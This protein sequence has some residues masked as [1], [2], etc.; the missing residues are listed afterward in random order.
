MIMPQPRVEQTF[1]QSS[2]RALVA[3]HSGAPPSTIS[4]YIL[5]R[6]NMPDEVTANALTTALG[7]YVD[8]YAGQSLADAQ[9]V[10]EVKPAA[11]GGF[12]ARIVLGFP[13]GGYQKE[14]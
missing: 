1:G 14:L 7:A 8:P 4:H 5:F 6:F 9:A 12:T 13:V 3:M 2:L 10:R 11:G